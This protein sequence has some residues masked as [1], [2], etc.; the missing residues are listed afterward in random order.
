MVSRFRGQVYSLRSHDLEL[1][2]AHVVET[3]VTSPVVV[4]VFDVVGNCPAGLFPA[5][6]RRLREKLLE[7]REE[8]LGD[9]V[10]NRLFGSC[11]E[12]RVAGEVR[13][14]SRRSRSG[15]LGRCG[16]SIRPGAGEL[17]V[18]LGDLL[19]TVLS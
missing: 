19:A 14:D 2:W 11:S 6:Q 13:A 17:G 1:E 9:G 18:P 4:V 5:R 3:R 10:V 16:G 8:A 7:G 15:S 12:G